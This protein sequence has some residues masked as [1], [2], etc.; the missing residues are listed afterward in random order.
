MAGAL[1]SCAFV[2]VARAFQ[3]LS[4]AGLGAFGRPLLIAFGIVS[5]IVAAAFVLSQADVKR[6]LA[7]SS[8]EHMGLLVLGL[9]FGGVGA[10]G[11]MLHVVNNALAKGLLFLAVGNVVLVTGTPLA[12]RIGGLRRVLP[13]S[14]GLLVVGLLAATGSP[15]F[16]SFVSEL[17]ILR[18]AVAGGHMVLALVAAG[19]IVV[20]FAGMARSLLGAV[21]GEPSVAP[22]PRAEDVWLLAGPVALAAGVLLLGLYIPTPLSKV[23]AG[24]AASL[25]GVSP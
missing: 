10:Y 12:A 4:A 18:A 14:A 11:S 13:V 15:P 24:A 2:G 7:Y 1:T 23:L 3:V 5:L 19:L 20:I 22:R 16:G 21:H 25:G 6:L 17:T 9:G 8:V